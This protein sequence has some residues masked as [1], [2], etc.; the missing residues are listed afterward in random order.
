[1]KQHED[2]YLVAVASIRLISLKHSLLSNT[3]M[4]GIRN[5]WC[6]R[7]YYECLQN[8]HFTLHMY[9]FYLWSYG[10]L[11]SAVMRPY[12]RCH[13]YH[14]VCSNYLVYDDN[15]VENL[16]TKAMIIYGQ[17]QTSY[18]RLAFKQDK[19]ANRRCARIL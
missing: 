12:G 18:K 19:K 3:S 16:F 8:Y 11:N 7:D 15:L 10:T 1:M 6:H 2:I 4:K 14:L 13:L 5:K 17:K 9:V